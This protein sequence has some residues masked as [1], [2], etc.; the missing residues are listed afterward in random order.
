[1]SFFLSNHGSFLSCACLLLLPCVPPFDSCWLACLLAHPECLLPLAHSRPS[2]SLASL[3]LIPSVSYSL[4]GWNGPEWVHSGRLGQLEGKRMRKRGKEMKWNVSS[5][6]CMHMHA[7]AC[8]A[9]LPL[10]PP[11]F[12]AS[13]CLRLP[14]LPPSGLCCL[15]CFPLACAGLR[16]SLW[17]ALP[18]VLPSAVL[19]LVCYPLP[20][21][22]LCATLCLGVSCLPPSALGCCA[23]LLAQPECFLALKHSSTSSSLASLALLPSVSYSLLVWSGPEW[24]HSRR[25]G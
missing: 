17:F 22:G 19:W 24:D 12:H 4:S 2:T 25:V 3:A 6:L 13:L 21:T 9:C 5:V 1:M 15:A 16:A 7:S 8:L 14:C 23:C 11:P 18:C 10:P 20:P